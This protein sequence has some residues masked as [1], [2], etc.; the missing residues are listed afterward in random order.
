V[1]HSAAVDGAASVAAA[2]KFVLQRAT[3]S[4]YSR[5]SPLYRANPRPSMHAVTGAQPLLTEHMTPRAS[6]WAH[7][8]DAAPDAVALE[9]QDAES[10]VQFSLVVT[11]LGSLLHHW[12]VTLGA[13][14]LGNSQAEPLGDLVNPTHAS[15]VVVDIFTRE[16]A[17]LH[18][19][20]VLSAASCAHAPWR[21]VQIRAASSLSART[22][23]CIAS[24]TPVSDA[25]ESS[26]LQPLGKEHITAADQEQGAS[27]PPVR[28][29]SL[30][31]V[32]SRRR[33]FSPSG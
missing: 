24:C 3:A 17:T 5:N 18:S 13:A 10:T 26:T 20:A 28:V 23:L 14:P 4:S 32:D 27:L 21:A 11:A 15:V 29:A 12:G 1:N 30:P 25:Q 33:Q 8:I 22:S 7:D 2:P 31:Q 6:L 9:E 19:L 16:L